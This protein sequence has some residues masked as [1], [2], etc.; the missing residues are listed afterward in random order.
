M[1]IHDEI[2]HQLPDTRRRILEL[3]D[4]SGDCPQF[5]QFFHRELSTYH[6]HVLHQNFVAILKFCRFFSTVLWHKINKP[7]Q[8]VRTN[9]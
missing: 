4:K 2:A 8:K 9:Y 1:I 7:L 3:I 6:L 5:Y